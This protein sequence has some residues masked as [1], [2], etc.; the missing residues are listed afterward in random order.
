MNSSI[1]GVTSLRGAVRVPSTSKSASTPRFLLAA[2]IAIL[3]LLPRVLL[4]AA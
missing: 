1:P 2:A 4:A 3:P